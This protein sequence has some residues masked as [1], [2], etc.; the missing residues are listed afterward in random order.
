M[1][2]RS[3]KTKPSEFLDRIAPCDLSF[4][5]VKSLTE[6][7]WFEA[8]GRGET[9]FL[10]EPREHRRDFSREFEFVFRAAF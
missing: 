5:G 4:P 10:T 1:A 7:L 8:P 2:A 9:R 6:Y 3:G